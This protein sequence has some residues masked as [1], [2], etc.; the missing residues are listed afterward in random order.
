M[1]NIKVDPKKVCWDGVYC[2]HVTEERD[3]W[4][5]LVNTVMTLRD[6]LKAGN[7]LSS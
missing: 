3:M 1:A 7:F 2:I 6:P 4:S 5:A